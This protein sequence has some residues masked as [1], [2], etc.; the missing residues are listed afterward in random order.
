MTSG[1]NLKRPKGRQ[2]GAVITTAKEKRC[3]NKII[4]Y[5][6]SFS[7]EVKDSDLIKM[8]GISRNTFY[9]YKANIRKH[10]KPIKIMIKNSQTEEKINMTQKLIINNILNKCAEWGIEHP[11]FYLIITLERKF[12]YENKLKHEVTD[13]FKIQCEGA[14]KEHEMISV[15]VTKEMADLFNKICVLKISENGREYF[16]P[17]NHRD[18]EK[19]KDLCAEFV[20]E[21]IDKFDKS[22]IDDV[23]QLGYKLIY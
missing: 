3:R 21:V 7:G 10:Y 5:S 4:E 17:M 6:V 19:I 14:N 23:F 22:G 16:Y 15:D 8:L 18:N 1:G 2:K 20:N 13:Y 11:P 12:S 9:K